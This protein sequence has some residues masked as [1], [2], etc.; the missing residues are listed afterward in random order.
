MDVVLSW[1]DYSSQG[2]CGHAWRH[3]GFLAWPEGSLGKARLWL[4]QQAL[5]VPAV[6]VLGAGMRLS[7][8]RETQEE[9]WPTGRTGPR[10][11]APLVWV[12][13]VSSALCPWP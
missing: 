13:G 6:L 11:C 1:D 7:V 5:C 2:V 9:R 10:R 8:L 12:F 4:W 3:L